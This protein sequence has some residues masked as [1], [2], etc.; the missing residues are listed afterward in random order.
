MTHVLEVERAHE[1]QWY[2]RAIAE[3]FFEREGFRQLIAANI[4]ALERMVPVGRN[5]RVLSLGCGTGEYERVLAT[6]SRSVVG[7]DLSPVAIDYAQ[8]RARDE[9]QDDRL[10]FLCG[11]VDSVD[12]DAA[13]IDLVVIFGVLHHLDAAQRAD[14]VR[15]V[16]RWLVPGGWCYARDPNARGL[17]RRLAGGSPGA[18]SSTAPTRLRWIPRR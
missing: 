5:T 9:H 11:P 15:R 13:S 3:R 2:R 1:D 4:A 14:V 18:T 16:Q 17:L 7:I 6:R 10:T 8:Q 12:L